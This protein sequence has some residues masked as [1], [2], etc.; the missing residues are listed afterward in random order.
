MAKH[1]RDVVL[2]LHR[3]KISYVDL[4]KAFTPTKLKWSDLRQARDYQQEAHQCWKASGRCGVVTLPT[5]SGK[6]FLGMTCIFSTQRPTLVIAPTLDLVAQWCQNLEQAFAIKVG[7][8]GGGSHE[9]KQITVSTYDSALIH[10]E[11]EGDKF[12]FILF[13]ECHHLPGASY[14]WIA[15]IAIAPYRLGLS[16]TPE[17]GDGGHALLKELIGPEVYRMSISSMKGRVLSHYRTELV[18]VP[19]L[20]E[21]EQLYKE[22]RSIYTGFVRH[23]N[24][25]FSSPS[26]WSNFVLL[27]S[28]SDAGKRAM[29]AYKKQKNIIRRSESKIKVLWEM[30]WQYREERIII[31]TNDNETA[32]HIGERFTLPVLT[33]QTSLK[34][35]KAFLAALRSG[36]LPWIVTSRVLNEGVDV[37]EVKVAIIVS[38]TGSVREHVQRL[39]RILRKQEGQQAVLIELISAHTGEA[40]QSQRRRAHEAYQ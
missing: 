33:H 38:G 12:G 29:A 18:E 7:T 1:Y 17:R 30:L 6:S 34:E 2:A 25:D 20:P 39:G 8:W 24:I 40:Y 23:E 22:E 21:E 11:R 37:P 27:S 15:N 35:R 10:L 9:T 36:T 19:L 31:F 4:A 3:N 26:G 13:D 5:G 28:K 16:A 14:R 32:Y